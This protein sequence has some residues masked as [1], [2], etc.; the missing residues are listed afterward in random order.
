MYVYVCFAESEAHKLLSRCNFL[1]IG[2]NLFVCVYFC[3][4]VCVYA[5][6]CVLLNEKPIMFYP[7]RI[8]L[9][10]DM[11]HAWMCVYVCVFC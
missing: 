1:E 5:C 10:L 3:V 7:H 2:H 4:C 11:A 8:F 6:V 9:K